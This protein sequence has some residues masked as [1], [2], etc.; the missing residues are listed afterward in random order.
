MSQLLVFCLQESGR[1]AWQP[2]FGTVV[3]IPLTTNTSIG[4]SYCMALT[5]M[6]SEGLTLNRSKVFMHQTGQLAFP[7]EESHTFGTGDVAR[8]F[9]PAIRSP[10]YQVSWAQASHQIFPYAANAQENF[11]PVQHHIHASPAP[12]NQQTSTVNEYVK[13]EREPRHTHPLTDPTST[14]AH[15]I[16]VSP[17]KQS[18]IRKGANDLQTSKVSDPEPPIPVD[19]FR[20]NPGASV[21]FSF[22]FAV[23]TFR[24]APELKHLLAYKTRKNSKGFYFKE[25]LACANLYDLDYLLHLLTASW[26]RVFKEDTVEVINP[27]HPWDYVPMRNERKRLPALRTLKRKELEAAISAALVTLANASVMCD[28]KGKGKGPESTLNASNANVGETTLI[29]LR[30]AVTAWRTYL[31]AI[32]ESNTVPVGCNSASVQLWADTF[33]PLID[34]SVDDYLPPI[35]RLMKEDPKWMASICEE[36][37]KNGDVRMGATAWRNSFE[38]LAPTASKKKP[39]SSTGTTNVTV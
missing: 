23:A 31:A 29:A 5:L 9:P 21:D 8:D 24:K 26:V 33:T 6:W 19:P 18:E 25:V 39:R 16:A 28:A 13:N 1:W 35:H 2:T 34:D 12:F 11:D 4:P 37:S 3:E 20:N 14:V 22:L 30:G 27:E 10:A 38:K 17:A 36:G 7:I 15:D 32:R